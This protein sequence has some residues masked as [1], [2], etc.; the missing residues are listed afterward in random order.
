MRKE[1]EEEK[2]SN[3]PRAKTYSK[4]L[5]NNGKINI[6]LTIKT[7]QVIQRKK[8]AKLVLNYVKQK[9]KEKNMKI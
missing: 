1:N 7:K 2:N 6:L 4:L 8:K 3:F 5:Y 9:Q